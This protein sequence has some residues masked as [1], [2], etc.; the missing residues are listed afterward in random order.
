MLETNTYLYEYVFISSLF[1]VKYHTFV[2]KIVN[3]SSLH[4]NILESIWVPRGY[5]F[6]EQQIS[7]RQHSFLFRSIP[8][9]MA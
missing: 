3:L 5:V 6:F 8:S 9:F 2:S 7:V 1:G 4:F